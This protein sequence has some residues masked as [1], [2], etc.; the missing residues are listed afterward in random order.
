MRCKFRQP[1]TGAG[2]RNV[3]LCWGKDATARNGAANP[4]DCRGVHGAG[5]GSGPAVSDRWPNSLQYIKEQ[6]AEV[7]PEVTNM[8]ACTN[9]GKFYG[10]IN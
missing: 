3:G 2:G 8:I 9:A 1:A 10:L 5:P 4:H 6:F 7:S